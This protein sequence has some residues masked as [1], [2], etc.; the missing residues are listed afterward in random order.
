MISN[1]AFVFLLP[2]AIGF[3][4]LMRFDLPVQAANQQDTAAKI[5]AMER[6]AMDRWIKGDPDGFL[7]ISDPE[8]VYFDPLVAARL[9]GLE[10]LRKYYEPARGKIKIDHYEFIAPRVQL[11]DDNTMAVLTFN[12]VS[13]GSAG[14]TRWNTTEVYR[15]NRNK[16]WRIIQT[17]WSPTQPKL[18]K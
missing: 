14:D 13:H 10:D 9:N 12:F 1:T 5:L 4:A 8:V 7:E 2:L 6:A 16:Q 15:L 3:C 18:Q 11:S 17:H